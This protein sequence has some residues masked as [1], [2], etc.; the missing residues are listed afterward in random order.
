MNE[1]VDKGRLLKVICENSYVLTDKHNSTS[2]GM[3]IDGINQA[4]E[5]ATVNNV[6]EVKHAHW[7]KV[8]SNSKATVYECSNCK[9]LTFGTSDYC[10][11]GA[12]MEVE[13]NGKPEERK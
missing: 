8:Y 1:Y 7:I 5:M 4:V 3:L 12:K 6:Q 13:Y 10:I 2:Y 11:C 9:H